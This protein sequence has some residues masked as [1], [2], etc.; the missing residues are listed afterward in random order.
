MHCYNTLWRLE[1]A[2]TTQAASSGPEEGP[3]IQLCLVRP[4]WH[5]PE[6]PLDVQLQPNINRTEGR[7]QGGARV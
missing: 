2:R 5:W 1:Q 6:P 4:G 3:T 7:L